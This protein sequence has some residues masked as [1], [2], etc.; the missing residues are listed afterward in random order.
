MS[1]CS[2]RSGGSD[3]SRII[4]T[5]PALHLSTLRSTQ[6]CAGPVHGEL[7]LMSGRFRSS[8][9]GASVM[10]PPR[11]TA[12]TLRVE[13]AAGRTYHQGFCGPRDLTTSWARAPARDA[14][15]PQQNF[16]NGGSSGIYNSLPQSVSGGERSVSGAAG[17]TFSTA[18]RGD[19]DV[20]RAHEVDWRSAG[21][22]R[23]IDGD[24]AGLSAGERL[25]A[26]YRDRQRDEENSNQQ[27]CVMRV[28]GATD[29]LDQRRGDDREGWR[30]IDRDAIN[31]SQIG[32]AS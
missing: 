13:R 25:I 21:G 27:T 24:D 10:A 2:P 18:R 29:G 1:H 26:H 8:Q 12:H 4:S 28:G 5:P 9:G 30:F 15:Q 20:P 3:R 17:G 23:W 19:G 22:S 16:Y 32:R 7:G 6:D 11:G 14:Q 31:D